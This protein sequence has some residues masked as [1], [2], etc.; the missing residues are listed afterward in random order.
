MYAFLANRNFIINLFIDFKKYL[1]YQ[2]HENYSDSLFPNN[3][4]LKHFLGMVLAKSN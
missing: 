1:R 4:Y 2:M 3:A